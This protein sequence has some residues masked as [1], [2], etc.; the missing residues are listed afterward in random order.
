M[1]VIIVDLTLHKYGAI[2]IDD[3]ST[4]NNDGYL[5]EDMVIR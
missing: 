5:G 2:N 4:C 3:N 1:D